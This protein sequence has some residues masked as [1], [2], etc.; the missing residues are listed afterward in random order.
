MEPPCSG[1]PLAGTISATPNSVSCPNTSVTLNSTGYTIG[2]NI[3]YLWQSSLDNS[4]WSDIIG[5][6]T[7]PY[8]LVVTSQSYYRLKIV[9]LNSGIV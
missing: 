1:T 3:T 2:C 9:C 7:I 6:N 8:S 5:A 4:T